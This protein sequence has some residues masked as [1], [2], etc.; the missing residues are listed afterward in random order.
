[1]KNRKVLSWLI[2]VLCLIPQMLFA[3]NLSVQGTVTDENGEAMIGVSVLVKGTS[4]GVITDLDGNFALSASS[5]STL[6]FSYIGYKTLEKK[7]TGTEMKVSLSPDTEILDEVVVIAYGQQKKVTVTGSVSN[8]NSKE[9]LKSP[10]ASLGNAISGKLPGLSTVQYSGLP[11]EDDPTIFIRG[12]ASLNGSTP[13]VLVDGVERSFTQIDPNEVADITILKD[14]SA[15]AVYGV[16]GANGVIL[17]TT[18]RGE[19]GKTNVSVSTSWGIQTVTKFL[20]M[21]NSYTYATTF[22]QAR[23]SDGNSPRFSDEVIEHFRT[24]DQPLLY[25]D[26]DWIDYIM[27][28]AA[29]QSQHNISVSGGNDVARYFVSLGMLDQDGMFKTFGEDPKSN[30]N[31]RRYNYRANLDLTLGKLHE[32]SINLGGRVE[33]RRT[34]GNNGGDDGE[35]YIFRYLMDAQPFSGAGIVDGRWIKTNPAL[36]SDEAA[37]STRDG[38]DTFYGQGYPHDNDQCAEPRLDLQVETGLYHQRL[39]LPHQRIVQLHILFAQRPYL[40]TARSIYAL[41]GCQW[42]N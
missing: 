17:V 31:Y 29:L 39:G 24:H 3:Q 8:V 14:A 34:I 16:R 11:G 1:M 23:L 2:A 19:S 12:Q 21:A 13:L 28:D 5:G 20:D 22:N 15:T 26:I 33:N 18:K 41:S 38:L 9:L 35:E 7:V 32:L 36:I 10:A 4:T 30:F 6:V 40:R 25:P 27:K 42:R 37:V